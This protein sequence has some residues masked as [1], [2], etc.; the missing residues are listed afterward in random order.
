MIVCLNMDKMLI[1]DSNDY[2]IKSTKTI[3]INKF[4]MKD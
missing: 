3:L 2:M 4:D 1:Q